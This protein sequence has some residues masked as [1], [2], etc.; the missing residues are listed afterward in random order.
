MSEIAILKELIKEEG[1][2]P[3]DKKH[4]T[5]TEPQAPK[6]SVSI[7]NLPTNTIIIKADSF[8]SSESFFR[9]KQGECKRADYIIVS[10]SSTHKTVIYMETK[11]TK[12]LEQ[13][14]IKQLK[15]TRCL[16]S[17]IIDIS[18]TFW[19]KPDFLSSYQHR[20]VSVA[21]TSMSKKR[22]RMK[23]PKGTH[24]TPEKMLKISWPKSINFAELVGNM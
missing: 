2:I 11:L 4:I 6:S 20:F 23:H 13:D 8:K 12:D 24:D 19:D 16:M 14:V 17:Y 15:A 3:R 21:H 5:L 18:K 22:T 1:L 9:G 10:E 7:S